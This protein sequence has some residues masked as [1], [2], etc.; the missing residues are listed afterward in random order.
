MYFHKFYTLTK[1]YTN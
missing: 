1:K